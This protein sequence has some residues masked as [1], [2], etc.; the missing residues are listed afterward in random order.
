[1]TRANSEIFTGPLNLSVYHR[2]YIN[3]TIFGRS[4]RSNIHYSYL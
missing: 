4:T 1:M 2:S 3:H